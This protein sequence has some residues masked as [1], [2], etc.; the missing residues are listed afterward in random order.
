MLDGDLVFDAAHGLQQTFLFGTG[1]TLNLNQNGNGVLGTGYNGNGTLRIAD[2]IAVSS[3][4]GYMGNNAGSS[5]TATVTGA[6]SKWTNS[7]SL[8]VA[9]MAMER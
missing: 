4:S 2:G 9:I 5:G 7:G 6:G 1:G 8:Y 3:S